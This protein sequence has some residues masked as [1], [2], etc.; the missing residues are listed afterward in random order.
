MTSPSYTLLNIHQG[1]LP[2][3]HFDLYRLATVSDLE[4]LG[5]DEHA[6]RDGVTWAGYFRAAGEAGVGPRAF[7]CSEGHADADGRSCIVMEYLDGPAFTP[8]L[9][10][11]PENLPRAARALTT[12]SRAGVAPAATDADP[13][14]ATSGGRIFVMSIGIG[15]GT[16]D[17]S[18]LLTM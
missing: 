16:Y 15:I 5:Y 9:I 3:Y 6:E 12:F 14:L 18:R 11:S 10:A 13:C 17:L 1:R 8:P 2:L 7:F 4:E